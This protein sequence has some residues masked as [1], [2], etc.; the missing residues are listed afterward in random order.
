MKHHGVHVFVELR[1]W[2][3]HISERANAMPFTVHET[4]WSS[5]LRAHV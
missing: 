3:R 1:T 4:S 2:L 5:S